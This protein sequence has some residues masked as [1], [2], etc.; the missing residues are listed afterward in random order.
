MYQDLISF[1]SAGPYIALVCRRNIHRLV[2]DG[3]IVIGIPIIIYLCYR[4]DVHIS[5]GIILILKYYLDIDI[6]LGHR[7][8]EYA[9]PCHCLYGIGSIPAVCFSHDHAHQHFTRSRRNV[10]YRQHF[11]TVET[12]DGIPMDRDLLIGISIRCQCSSGPVGSIEQRCGV[13]RPDNYLRLDAFAP[14]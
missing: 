4:S 2:Q 13:G 10:V 1:I 12:L 3:G 11:P 14:L 6:R 8:F 7:A 9:G 5:Q